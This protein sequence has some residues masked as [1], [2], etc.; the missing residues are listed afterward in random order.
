MKAF[1]ALILASMIVSVLIIAQPALAY[2]EPSAGVK[3]GD[4]IEYT[5]SITGPPLDPSRNL[6]WYR[7]DILE[8]DGT[9]FQANMTSLSVNGTISSAVWTFNLTEGQVQGWEVIPANLSV[10][11]EFFDVFKS[12]N[13]TIE[14]EEQKIVAG[15]SRTI[16]HASDPG[17]LDKEW[18]KAT[19][20]YVHSVEHTEKYTVITNAIATNMWSPDVSP[21]PNLTGFYVLVAV[22]VVL[23]VLIVASAI[24]VVRRKRLTGFTLSSSL[25][26]KI[27]VLTIIAVIL[28]EIGTI[29]FF[30]FYEVGLSFAE[31]NLI[32]QTLW[33]VLILVSMWFRMKGNYFMHEILMLIVMSAW[34]VGF[35]AVLFM[36]PFSGSSQILATTPLRLVMNA[37]HGIF[38]VPALVFGLWLV[39]L[40][41]PG[42]ASFPAKSRR[43]AQLTAF[44]WVPSYVVGVLDFLL[45]HTAVFG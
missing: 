3:K 27:A 2:S 24:V 28:L 44:F 8:V 25:Q 7:N 22:I 20:V 16:T 12:A 32:M 36:D 42:P 11:D 34:A 39:V 40:W 21:E 9:W 19:G 41:R 26:G 33:T 1:T 38:S 30:P 43:I 45:L 35:T 14:G 6:T 29:F 31:F 13:I 4:W 17:K 18:D 15:A 23:T 10:G 5:I 37:L